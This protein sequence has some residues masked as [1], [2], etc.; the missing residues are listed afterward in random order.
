MRFSHSKLDVVRQCLK[1]YHFK[2]EIRLQVDEDEEHLKFGNL[3]HDVAEHYTGGGKKQLLKLFKKLHKTYDFKLCDYKERLKI[4]MANI[5]HFWKA[6]L[7]ETKWEPE[8]E[9]TVDITDDIRVTGKVDVL[10]F[11][12]NRVRIIDYK[13]N[14]S[15]KY[16]NHTNQL[17]MYMYLV[18]NKYGISYDKMECE[19]VYLSL[20]PQEK[21]GTEVLNEGYENIHKKYDLDASDVAVLLEEI[22][23]IH[24]RIQRARKNDKWRSNPTWFNC[25]FCPFSEH[26]D[27]KFISDK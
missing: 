17:A 1:K 26:C 19:I 4:A 2:Y 25:T 22:E 21:D 20:M 3:C 5:H 8:Q 24:H 16:A 14:K 10:I 15:K 11:Y 27:E 12:G 18:H 6:N 7:K 13:T 9:I 23:A